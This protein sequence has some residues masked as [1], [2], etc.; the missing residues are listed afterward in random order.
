MK[1][2]SKYSFIFSALIISAVFGLAQNSLAD[3]HTAASCSFDDASGAIAAASAGDIVQIPE[4]SC[5]WDK[6]LI[7][8]TSIVLKGAGIDKTILKSNFTDQTT[9]IIKYYPSS[10]SA[11]GVFRLTGFTI[12]GNSMTNGLYLSNPTVIAAKVRIDHNKITNAGGTNAGRGIY[13]YGTIYGVI[14]SD[15]FVNNKIQISSDNDAGAWPNLNRDFGNENNI[16]Y[17]DNTITSNTSFFDSGHGGRYAARYNSF[18][19]LAGLFP[20]MDMHGNQSGNLFAT[21]VGEVY[22]NLID[23]S[24]LYG[25]Q[26]LDQRGAQVMAFYNNMINNGQPI[27]GLKIRE[28]YTDDMRLRGTATGAG[29]DYLSGVGFIN[30]FLNKKVRIVA[31]TGM[32]QNRTIAAVNSSSKITVSPNWEIIPSTDSVYHVF[33]DTTNYIQHVTNSH[34][35]NNRKNGTV[36]LANNIAEDDYDKSISMVNDPPLIVENREF[37]QQKSETFD[38][39]TGVGCGTLAARPQTCTTG[40]A[41]WATNQSCTDLAGMVGAH[42]TNPISGTL[43]KC[44]ATNTWNAYYQPYTYPHPLRTDCTNFPSIC[45]QTGDSTP[46]SAP[47]GLLIAAILAVVQEHL[48]FITAIS[49]LL[50]AAWSLFFFKDHLRIRF[51]K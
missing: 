21:M 2:N 9:G 36:L 28:E 15:T 19:A 6:S 37:W 44:T 46:P 20:A 47:T 41:Y 50:L 16:F 3:T 25:G 5:A 29:A 11:A 4:G 30:S 49:V 13:I 26:L 38:G 7:I 12:D 8:K 35:W 43:Y 22:G 10:P 39:T 45:D 51:N 23:L 32:G 34:Y 33:D 40:V 27:S 14:D 24:G 1:I 42:P 18:T 31:G 17:E 48:K